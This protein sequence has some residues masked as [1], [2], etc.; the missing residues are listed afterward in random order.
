MDITIPI[1]IPEDVHK[2]KKQHVPTSPPMSSIKS[3]KYCALI[4]FHNAIF[5]NQYSI[6]SQYHIET[7]FYIHKV[8]G[9]GTVKHSYTSML[10]TKISMNVLHTLYPFSSGQRINLLGI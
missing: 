5:F 8:W 9:R 4:T 7:I 6:T 3:I 2:S 1:I 10:M